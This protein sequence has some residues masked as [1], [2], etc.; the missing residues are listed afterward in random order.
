M[1]LLGKAPRALRRRELH[2]LLARDRQ[3]RALV[4]PIRH[5][6][7]RHPGRNTDEIQLTHSS[8]HGTL[9]ALLQFFGLTLCRSTLRLHRR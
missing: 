5:P 9:E 1:R 4:E 2:G 7:K 8:H 6:R 3:V